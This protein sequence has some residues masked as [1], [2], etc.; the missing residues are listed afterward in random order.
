M[1]FNQLSE[2]GIYYLQI[3]VNVEKTLTQQ[4]SPKALPLDCGHGWLAL[5]FGPMVN[6]IISVGQPLS[7]N[8]K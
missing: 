6:G 8:R 2:S 5:D 3:S 4:G 1:H 7:V